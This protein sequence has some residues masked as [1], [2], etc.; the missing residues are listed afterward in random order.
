MALGNRPIGGDHVGFRHAVKA[1]FDAGATIPARTYA[2]IPAK[3]PNS[4]LKSHMAFTIVTSLP[5][6]VTVITL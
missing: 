1:P 2:G 5:V 4:T 6:I 3:P